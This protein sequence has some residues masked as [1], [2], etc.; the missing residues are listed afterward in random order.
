LPA[1][2][3][4][5][6]LVRDHE[7]ATNYGRCAFA[8]G[9]QIQFTGTEKRAGIVNGAMGRIERI[10]GTTLS[11]KLA[12][13][14]GAII[15]VD[16]ATFGQ[17]RHGLSRPGANIRSN[18][19]ALLAS[20]ARDGR[21][22]CPHPAPAED[23][24]LC[25]PHPAAKSGNAGGARAPQPAR[26]AAAGKA[27]ARGRFKALQ[28]GKIAAA[29][30]KG[31][32]SRSAEGDFYSDDALPFYTPDWIALWNSEI[33]SSAGFINDYFAASSNHLS[34]NL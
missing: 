22:C 12:G 26:H 29:T 8:V 34:P 33:D 18:L 1:V 20:L 7:P 9:D 2:D 27:A 23:R 32:A 10:E 31:T 3:P 16:T 19:S 11:L 21:L 6:H 25:F 13:G 17:F 15:T 30:A 5:K 4:E 24:T 28:S 14:T